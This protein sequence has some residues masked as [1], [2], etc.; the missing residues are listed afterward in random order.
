MLDA[1]DRLWGLPAGAEVTLESNP[2]SA[3]ARNFRGYRTAGVNRVSVGV[4]ALDD[5][6]L[7]TLGRQH[8][9][10]EAVAAFRLAAGIFPRVSFDLIYA[11]PGQGADQWRSELTAALGEQQGHMSLYQ[12]TIED[13][14]RYFDLHRA[15]ALAMPDEDLGARLF[16]ITQELTSGAGLEAY[17]VS[18]HAAPGHESRHNLLY[19]RYGE[20][21]GA[22]PGAH[23]RIVLG[24]GRRVALACERHPETWRGLVTRQGH[25]RAEAAPLSRRQQGLEFLLMGMRLREGVLL[26][27]YEA[28]AGKPLAREKLEFLHDAGLVAFDDD[29]ARLAA[30]ANGRRV[31]NSLIAALTN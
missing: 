21:A 18:N 24:D 25:G 7:K 23:S 26:S 4:Q 28:V 5:A 17:E 22:G 29:G 3:E 20:Y 31:L 9:A 19:W 12:L 10:H 27:S 13:G 6:D 1:V 11:R 8:T 15:G 30:T 2:T 16:D 14:T